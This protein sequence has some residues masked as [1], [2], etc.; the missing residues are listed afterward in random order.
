MK[1]I[2]QASETQIIKQVS[3]D[4]IQKRFIDSNLD[5]ARSL[6]N[7]TVLIPGTNNF[8]VKLL[9]LILKKKS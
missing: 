7:S 4:E 2:S 6:L 3:S 8:L 9:L 5:E 1:S